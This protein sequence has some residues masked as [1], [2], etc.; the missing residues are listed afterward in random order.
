MLFDSPSALT[1]LLV[2]HRISFNQFFLC[3]FLY[4]DQEAADGI[5]LVE[6]TQNHG[7]VQIFRYM[8]QVTPWSKAELDDLI[9]K[10]LLINKSTDDKYHPDMM[11]V[12][13]KFI[14][15]IFTQHEQFEQF[16]KIYPPFTTDNRNPSGPKITLKGVPKDELETLYRQK[17]PNLPTH[18]RLIRATRYA[19][20][21][22][23]ISVG[24]K[25]WLESHLWEEIEVEI[26]VGAPNVRAGL[27]HNDE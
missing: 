15:S 27:A 22:K 24:I 19:K 6:Y 17:I 2:K 13:Q 20:E 10:G 16:W 14:D 8:S 18:E 26:S 9:D 4:L 25:K 23:M 7:S 12:T 11:V 1:D 3:Y 5:S 21:N